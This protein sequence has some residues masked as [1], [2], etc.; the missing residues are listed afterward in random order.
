MEQVR[1]ARIPVHLNAV[2]IGEKTV[3]KGCK[4]RNVSNQGLLL[5]C[6]ADGRI[7]TFREGDHVDIHLLFQRPD[8]TKYLTI[9]A[10]VRHVDANG[11]GV[12]FSQPDMELVRLIESYRIDETQSIEA[13]ISHRRKVPGPSGAATVVNHP[14]SAASVYTEQRKPAEE[15]NGRRFYFF[16]LL[17]MVVAV[18]IVTAD[19]LRALGLGSRVAA[20]ESLVGAHNA[21]L[22]RFQSRL[23]AYD[24]SGAVADEYRAPEKSGGSV[25]TPESEVSATSLLQDNALAS[26]AT[27]ETPGISSTGESAGSASDGLSSEEE[28]TAA[29]IVGPA[30]LPG[31]DAASEYVD[32]QDAGK[33]GPWVINLLSS[34]NKSDADQFADKARKQGI[35]VEQGT[36]RLKGREFFRVQLTGFL[37]AKQAEKSARP[38]KNKLGLKDVWIFKP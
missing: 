23:L 32:S 14:A 20:L 25:P 36:I 9:S 34:P 27:T 21:E 15:A 12:E 35:P 33:R 13:T 17:L 8:G 29:M 37:T 22:A 1:H 19:Y 28:T 3:P 30:G 26:S 11:I 7:Q 38:V 4:V 18:S 16:G 5:Q 10:T 24:A 6:D 31:Q 2:L